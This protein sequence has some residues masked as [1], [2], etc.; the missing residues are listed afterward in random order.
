MKPINKKQIIIALGAVLVIGAM[1]FG[2]QYNKQSYEEFSWSI[3]E[4]G[5][6]DTSEPITKISLPT[7]VRDTQS[8]SLWLMPLPELK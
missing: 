4:I 6:T 8:Y 3:E 1:F 2:Y 7:Q 5:G